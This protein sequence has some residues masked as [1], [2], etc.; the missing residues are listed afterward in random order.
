MLI[1]E[2]PDITRDVKGDMPSAGESE[3]GVLKPDSGETVR[4]LALGEPEGVMVEACDNFETR[5]A[6]EG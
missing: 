4:S 5:D 6:E 3:R 2:L 1:V